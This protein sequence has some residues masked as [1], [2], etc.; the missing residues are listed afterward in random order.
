MEIV[1]SLLRK[2]AVIYTARSVY[3]LPDS[4]HNGAFVVNNNLPPLG[5]SKLARRSRNTCKNLEI[6]ERPGELG[7]VGMGLRKDL[8]R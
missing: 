8:P 3:R 6:G 4:H 1:W 7:R 5:K 2:S